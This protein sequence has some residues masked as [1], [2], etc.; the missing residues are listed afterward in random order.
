M[1][2]VNYQKDER[3]SKAIAGS[4]DPGERLVSRTKVGVTLSEKPFKVPG[5][6]AWYAMVLW[7]YSKNPEQVALNVLVASAEAAEVA[8]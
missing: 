7:N 1:K 2:F 4:C 8:G 5:S 6:E 3:V